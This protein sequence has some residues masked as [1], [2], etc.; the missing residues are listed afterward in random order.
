[1]VRIPLFDRMGNRVQ[2]TNWDYSRSDETDYGVTRSIEATLDC[3]PKPGSEVVVYGHVCKFRDGI[4]IQV[5][6]A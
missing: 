2:V 3:T 6:R 1:M 5:C 4:L